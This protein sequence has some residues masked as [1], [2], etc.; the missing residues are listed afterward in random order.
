MNPVAQYFL[1]IQVQTSTVAPLPSPCTRQPKPSFSL[2]KPL[3]F[4]WFLLDSVDSASKQTRDRA[5][6]MRAL[7]GHCPPQI[8]LD[9]GW[10]CST[11][12]STG[13]WR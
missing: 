12:K 4:T 6:P 2:K 13:S 11:E 10:G 1:G 7:Y 8:I 3:F 9:L 5:W